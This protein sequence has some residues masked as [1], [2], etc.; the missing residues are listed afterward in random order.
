MDYGFTCVRIL[1]AAALEVFETDSLS[2][3]WTS[4]GVFGTGQEHL[5]LM[6]GSSLMI[7]HYI[8]VGCFT[9]G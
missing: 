1:P 2:Y 6:A 7:A 4:D 5:R 3:C 9:F 8:G